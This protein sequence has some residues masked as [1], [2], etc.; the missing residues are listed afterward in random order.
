MGGVVLVFGVGIFF[1]SSLPFLIL[2]EVLTKTT[3]SILRG[4]NDIID[5]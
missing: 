5:V 1:I 3:T 2:Y 4:N